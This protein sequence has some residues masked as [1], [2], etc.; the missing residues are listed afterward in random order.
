VQNRH[1][2]HPPKATEREKILLESGFTGEK[3][4][5]KTETAP[6]ESEP[7]QGVHQPG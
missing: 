7:S 4:I 2:G 1:L 5:A 3:S 6:T